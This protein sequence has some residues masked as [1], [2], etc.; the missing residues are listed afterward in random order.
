MDRF[1][2][3]EHVENEIF[4]CIQRLRKEYELSYAEMI[5]ILFMK[6][7]DVWHELVHEDET[8]D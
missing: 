6:T 4:S 3:L 2:R 7:L 8:T 1:E 5:G